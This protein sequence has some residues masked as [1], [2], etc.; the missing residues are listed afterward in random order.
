ML[1]TLRFQLPFTSAHNKARQLWS[2]S[3]NSVTRVV[4]ILNMTGVGDW[5][6]WDVSRPGDVTL[7]WL[8]WKTLCGRRAV[9]VVGGALSRHH[10]NDWI[11]A[12][13]RC[14]EWLKKRRNGQMSRLGR[15][16]AWLTFLFFVELFC[17]PRGKKKVI[18]KVCH[19]VASL[20][21]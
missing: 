1:K 12:G 16:A 20:W 18:S 9:W 10:S 14:F 7:S 2:V 21:R 6:E 8:Q 3:A 15:E 4:W 11:T 13:K 17:S 5:P 19:Q